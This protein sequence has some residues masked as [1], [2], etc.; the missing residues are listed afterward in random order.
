MVQFG[1]YTFNAVRVRLQSLPSITPLTLTYYRYVD[2]CPPSVIQLAAFL[3][4]FLTVEMGCE[5]GVLL[6]SSVSPSVSFQL[7][8]LLWLIARAKTIK[9]SKKRRGMLNE[10]FEPPISDIFGR[11]AHLRGPGLV[12]ENTLR[13]VGITPVG[14]GSGNKSHLNIG[15]TSG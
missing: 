6:A 15:F 5:F 13:D 14:Y 3:M 11:R 2:W 1:R 12:L 10:G 4:L 9:I 7:L 8:L